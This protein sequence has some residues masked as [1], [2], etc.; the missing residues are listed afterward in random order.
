[1]KIYEWNIHMA[2]TFS[3]NKGYSIKAW[4]ADE[5]LCDNPDVI[6]LTEFVVSKGWDYFQGKLEEKEYFWF[7]SNTSGKNGI[8]IAIKNNAS[9]D[10]SSIF[11]Y[12]HDAVNNSEIFFVN[13]VENE[14]II[15]LPDFFEI[16]LKINQ[17]ETSIIGVRIREGNKKSQFQALDQYLSK[18]NHSVVCV[19]DFNVY[20][21]GIWRT[22]D[23]DKLPK[24]S[25][26]YDLYTP[27]YKDGDNWF[28]Y[29]HRDGTL[30]Q[31]DHLITN[32]KC[33]SVKYDWNFVT[34]QNG[35]WCIKEASNKPKGMPD[36]AILKCDIDI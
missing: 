31:L 28:S 33:S 34:R 3:C 35:Y 15:L 5:I 24:T 30:V 36:H 16:K 25:K 29:V 26:K 18:L 23:N 32:I 10:F 1:M 2:A 17:K 20:W 22:K 21:P 6:V 4:I 12:E 14:D 9:Y 8:L 11:N 7:V 13:K 27:K 19:G